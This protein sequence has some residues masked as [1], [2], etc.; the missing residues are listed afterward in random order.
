MRVNFA[1]AQEARVWRA[2][3][4]ARSRLAPTARPRPPTDAGAAPMRIRA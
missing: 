1:A 4:D 2:L 3:R